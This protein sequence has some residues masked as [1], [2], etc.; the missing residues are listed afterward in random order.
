M[1]AEVSEVFLAVSISVEAVESVGD[2]PVVFLDEVMCEVSED[3]VVL[4]EE[5]F[6]GSDERARRDDLGRGGFM[7]EMC[8]V[9]VVK[10]GYLA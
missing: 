1:F 6:T 4:A 7:T 10:L 3:L 9:G 2:G 5:N 8:V